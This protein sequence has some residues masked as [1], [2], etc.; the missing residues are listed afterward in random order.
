MIALD[1]GLSSFRAFR[2]APD[3]RVVDQRSA[4]AGILTI[5]PGGFEATLAAQLGD[6]R[7]DRRSSPP[8]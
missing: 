6:W 3:G 1:W 2:L 8:A 5:A 7:D 4:A